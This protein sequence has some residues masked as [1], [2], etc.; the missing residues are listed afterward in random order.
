MT[1]L[2]S[3]F[4]FISLIQQVVWKSY[5]YIIKKIYIEAQYFKFYV[6][7]AGFFSLVNE[8]GA[9][10]ATLYTTITKL[11]R[12]KVYKFLSVDNLTAYTETQ[13]TGE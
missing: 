5:S 11:V 6:L 7:F 3:D 9:P 2:A 10:T 12:E 1:I 13:S 8:K 4:D